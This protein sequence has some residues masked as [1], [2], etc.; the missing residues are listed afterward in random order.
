[1]TA[2]FGE[3]L[4][5]DGEARRMNFCPPLPIGSPHLARTPDEELTGGCTACWRGYVATW[6]IA[7]DEFYLTEINGPLGDAPPPWRKITEGRIPATWFSG[8][9]RVPQGKRLQYVHMGFGSTYEEEVHIKVEAGRVVGRRV[10]DNRD[11]APRKRFSPLPGTE[12]RFDGD[13]W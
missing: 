13:D 12:N 5:L 11:G 8:V 10:I 6:E 3:V 7:D 1:M 4:I 9:L 2:Q